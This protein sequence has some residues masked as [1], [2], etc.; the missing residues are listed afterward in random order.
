MAETQ[1]GVRVE[2]A[3]EGVANVATGL[4]VLDHLIGELALT[5]T[6]FAE[7]QPGLQVI[8]DEG[9]LARR[10]VRAVGPTPERER[11]QSVYQDLAD[12][13]RTGEMFRAPA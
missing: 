1:T 4:P 7:W 3:R 13:L 8:L 12:C 9:C 11:I 10:I 6:G 2:L 5:E